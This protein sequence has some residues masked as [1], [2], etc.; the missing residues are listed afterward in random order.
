MS[1]DLIFS[2]HGYFVYKDEYQQQQKLKAD[3]IILEQEKRKV[4]HEIIQLRENP[5]VLEEVIHRE[6]GYVYP[7]EYMLIMPETTQDKYNEIQQR[8]GHE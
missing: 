1:W 3:I 2:D 8:S 5:K 7:D 4:K 6:L